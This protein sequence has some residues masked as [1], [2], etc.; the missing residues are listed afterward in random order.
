MNSNENAAPTVEIGEANFDREVLNARQTVVVELYRHVR[1]LSLWFH[2]KAR[3]G[4]LVSRLIRYVG[5][6]Q[7]LVVPM[8]VKALILVGMFAL[9]FALMFWLNWRFAMKA[10][11]APGSRPCQV[12]MPV[13]EEIAAACARSRILRHEIPA[14]QQR[15][16]AFIS[17][18]HDLV[19]TLAE[20]NAPAHVQRRRPLQALRLQP[21]VQARH[22]I[23]SRRLLAR[24]PPI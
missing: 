6:V 1:Y 21:Q 13:L 2:N 15:A 14:A 22:T 16:A 18:N 11:L 23:S 5:L 20:A 4:D 7:G 3:T 9:M 8:R 10:L 17:G 24:F 19:S 12:L